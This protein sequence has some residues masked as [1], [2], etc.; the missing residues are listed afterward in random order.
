VGC[1]AAQD[2]VEFFESRIRPLLASKCHACHSGTTVASGGLRLDTREGARKGGRRGPAVIPGQ[3]DLSLILRAVSFEDPALKMPPSG[4][5]SAQE[6]ADLA[7]WIRMGAPDPRDEGGE[8]A[9]AAKP[10]PEH[11]AFQPV[12][13]HAVPSVKDARWPALWI[14]RFLLAK[15]EAAKL[16]PAPPASRRTLIRRVSYDLTGLPPTPAEIDAFLRDHSPRAFEKVVDRLLASPH[17]GERWARHWLDLARYAETDGHEFDREK[18][19]AWRYRDYVIRAFNDDLPYDQFVRE[20]IAGDILPCQRTLKEGLFESAVG[21][22]FFA[23]GEERNAADDLAQVRADKIDNQ[24]DTLSK[25]FLGLTVACAR[26]HDH[27]FDPVSQREYYALAGILDSKRAIQAWLDMPERRRETERLHSE[28][29]GLNEA[30]SGRFWDAHTEKARGTARYLLAGTEL[31]AACEPDPPKLAAHRSLDAA[32]LTAW[33]GELRQAADEPDHVLHPLAA[34]AGHYDEPFAAR[35]AALRERLSAWIASARDEVVLA[36]FSR[37]GYHGWR[38][39]GPAFG[40]APQLFLPPQQV[41]PGYQG[42][43]LANSFR[44]GADELTGM[45]TSPTFRADRKYLHVR[46]AGGS[47][48]TSARQAGL[49]RVSL[50]GDGRD[51]AVTPA[52]SRRLIWKTA[53]L[54]KMLGEMAFVEIADRTRASHIVVEKIV[55]SDRRTP[56]VSGRRL[57]DC[58]MRMLEE[59]AAA[60]L[61]KLAV[62]YEALFEESLTNRDA[63]DDSRW[64]AHTVAAVHAANGGFDDSD[65]LEARRVELA[66]KLPDAAYGLVSVDDVPR[67]APLHIGGNHRNLGATVP[68]GFLRILSDVD[69]ATWRKGS[70]RLALAQVIAKPTNPLTARV[71]VN[72]V[73][74]HHFGQGLVR[75][76]DNFGSTGDRP[77]HP[78]LLDTL[79][80]R[81]LEGGWSLKALHREIVLSSAYRMSNRAAAAALEADPDNRL[82]HHFPVRRLEAEAI[83]DAILAVSGALD[84]SVYGPSVP[85]HISEYQDGRGKPPSGPLDGAGR[86][87]IYVGVRRNFLPP[88]FLAFD[89]P[90]T[91]TTSGRR[92]ASTVPSQALIL[93]NNEFVLRQAERWADSTAR[94]GAGGARVRAMYAAAFGRAPL[95]TEIARCLRFVKAQAGQYAGRDSQFRAWA[96]LAHALFNTKEFIFIQ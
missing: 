61:D 65:A 23:L 38:V 17:Y 78:K 45:L 57:N 83:R 15:L 68:R 22:T 4:K 21:T 32:L 9:A 5:L 55:L 34:L 75:T 40:A 8:S 86:R 96:D 62:R 16:R 37:N 10:A 11:W 69:A 48:P 50:V 33:Y 70:G 58:V 71:I 85:P 84:R 79:A 60:S 14:D 43:P 25:T 94:Y 64:L 52:G 53:G 59:G 93:M 54:G 56:P 31:L 81:F 67:D 87:S 41:L 88:M 28:I 72:R 77:S 42:K 66:S 95:E 47:D 6:I 39:D 2:G 46:L 92:G 91:V 26:C 35:A 1:L 74:K 18:P 36:D 90:M 44:S 20:H 29:A 12:R 13:K 76:P 19:N 24:I 63:D 89:Y 49:L 3:E 30:L 82:L 73:W 7:A 51:V 27:K 80:A